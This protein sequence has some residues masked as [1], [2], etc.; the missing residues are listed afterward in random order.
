MD[1]LRLLKEKILFFCTMSE[2]EVSAFS[3][4]INAAVLAKS[5]TELEEITASI[6]AEQNCAI[7]N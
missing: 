5:T 7:G 6:R 4:F 1:E 2:S 3:P